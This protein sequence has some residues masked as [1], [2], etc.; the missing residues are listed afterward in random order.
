MVMMVVVTA[1][2]V[3]SMTRVMIV[4][5]IQPVVG[6]TIVMMKAVMLLTVIN[7]SEH[8]TPAGRFLSLLHILAP[9]DQSVV[10]A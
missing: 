9:L 3:V 8:I 1:V 7:I 5:L 10:Q 6:V 4:T 2:M